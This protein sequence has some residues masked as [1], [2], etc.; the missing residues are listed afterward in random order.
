MCAIRTIADLKES[1]VLVLREWTL[2]TAK[3]AVL[4]YL[5]NRPS[6]HVSDIIEALDMEPDLAFRT[7]DALLKEGSVDRAV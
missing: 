6:A 1:K 2:T 4:R 5:R 3:A 7:V